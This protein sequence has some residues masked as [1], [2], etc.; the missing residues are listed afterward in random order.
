M[1]GFQG[2]TY[3]I[4]GGYRGS[5]AGRTAFQVGIEGGYRGS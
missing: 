2:G 4:Q 5:E 3:S 1:V